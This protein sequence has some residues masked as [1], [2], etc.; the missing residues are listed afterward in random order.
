MCGHEHWEEEGWRPFAAFSHDVAP[1]ETA[2]GD[3]D[4]P[5]VREAGELIPPG[6]PL[7]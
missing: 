2:P 1:A 6:V 4:A 3:A 5:L 7:S